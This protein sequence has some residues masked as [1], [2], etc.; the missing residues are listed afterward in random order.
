MILWS[1]ISKALLRSINSLYVN[2]V[3]SVL[4]NTSVTLSSDIKVLCIFKEM[5]VDI[6][7]FLMHLQIIRN[8]IML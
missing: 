1:T 6:L 3:L 4:E 5:H 2:F 8:L 7:K